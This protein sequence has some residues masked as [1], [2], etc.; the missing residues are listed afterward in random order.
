V[1]PNLEASV[2]RPL[3]LL[4]SLLTALAL[5]V[6]LPTSSTAADGGTVSG[7]VALSGEPQVSYYVH[8]YRQNGGVWAVEGTS[9]LFTTDTYVRTGL[10][11]GTYRFRIVFVGL[12]YVAEY[13]DG[14]E[15]LANADSAAVT[16]GGTTDVDWSPVPLGTISGSLTAL[17][18]GTPTDVVPHA[19]TMTP[20]GAWAVVG[21]TAPVDDGSYLISGLPEGTYRLGFTDWSSYYPTLELGRH[22]WAQ[23]YWDD[24]PSAQE[25]TAITLGVGEDRTG[26]DAVL[27]GGSEIAGRVTDPYGVGIPAVRVT[28][29]RLVGDSFQPLE[30]GAVT[31]G[32]GS[33]RV[34]GMSLGT[35]RVRFDPTLGRFRGEEW[36]RPIRLTRPSQVRP[37]DA[38]LRFLEPH[39]VK[40]QKRPELHG[41]LRVGAV[42]SVSRGGWRPRDAALSYRWVVA[43]RQVAMSP[44]NRLTLRPAYRGKVIRVRVIAKAPDL[45]RKVVTLIRRGWG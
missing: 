24:E 32:D 6:G 20:S 35:Y 45:R 42:L 9:P 23:E 27:E 37:A 30:F 14:Q 21:N 16:E 28:V 39:R 34:R 18:G 25:A 7:S 22:A 11:A 10:T 19:E 38:Q 43:G 4:V 1:H 29:R 15:S 40:M 8:A 5:L 12:D 17:G 33:F 26:V 3:V 36:G 41:E 31:R 2:R 44:V 13:W